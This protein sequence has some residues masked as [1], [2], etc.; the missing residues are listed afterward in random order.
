MYIIRSK[1]EKVTYQHRFRY[2]EPGRMKL[3]EKS[4]TFSQTL[5]PFNTKPDGTVKNW[6]DIMKE[7]KEEG[8]KWEA[9]CRKELEANIHIS[10]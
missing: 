8:R 5:N 6:G 1:Y 7:L 3:R 10:A 4:K 9:D 2:K